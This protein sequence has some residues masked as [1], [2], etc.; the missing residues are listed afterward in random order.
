M[1]CTDCK[2]YQS[3]IDESFFNAP[4]EC[5]RRWSANTQFECKS[6]QQKLELEPTNIESVRRLK[7]YDRK[8]VKNHYSDWRERA[9]KQDKREVRNQKNKIER[10]KKCQSKNG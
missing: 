5:S 3:A 8:Q 2:H 1:K 7:G 4:I 6:F 10:F 9:R